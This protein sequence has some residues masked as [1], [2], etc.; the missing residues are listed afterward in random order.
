MTDSTYGKDYH[1]GTAYERRRMTGHALD[2]EH[3]P[4]LYKR[5]PNAKSIPLSQD[6]TRMASMSLWDVIMSSGE[7]DMASG[8]NLESLAGLLG[9]SYGITASVR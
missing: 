8:M 9:M 7:S 1:N 2:W 3:R 5:Y 6:G 4:D